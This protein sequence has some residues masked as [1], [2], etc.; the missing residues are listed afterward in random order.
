[1][2]MAREE[3]PAALPGPVRV[4]ATTMV[5]SLSTR[6]SSRIV[7]T[8]LLVPGVGKFSVAVAPVCAVPS[9]AQV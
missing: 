4:S 2:V 9:A 7:M 1:M 3:S 6:A 5:S 8:K